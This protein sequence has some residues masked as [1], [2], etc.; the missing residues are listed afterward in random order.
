[1]YYNTTG[2]AN[3]SIGRSSLE[4]NTI[5]NENIAIG[6]QALAANVTGS[7]NVAIGRSSMVGNTGGSINTAIGWATNSGNFSCSVILGACA[8][9]TANNQFVVGA[10]GAFNAGAV[11]VQS[12]S[13]THVWAVNINGQNYKIPLIPF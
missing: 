8:T 11:T 4:A 12:I 3:I 6:R 5:G 1:M 7:Q 9:A 2:G 10:T 13:P